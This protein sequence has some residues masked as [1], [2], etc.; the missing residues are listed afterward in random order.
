MKK[1]FTFIVLSLLSLAVV[2]Q[3][4]ASVTKPTSAKDRLAAKKTQIA[5]KMATLSEIPAVYQQMN[6][7]PVA[8]LAS[9]APKDVVTLNFTS[10]D[11]FKYQPATGDWFLSMSCMD[12]DK[13]EFGY[14]VKLD[15][16]APADNCCG[17]FTYDD[18]DLEYS[19]MF[20]PTGTTTY[21]DVELEVSMQPISTN[22][23]RLM[24]EANITG[25]DGITYKVNCVHEL[26]APADTVNTIINNV[27]LI[28]NDYDFT[29]AG[30]NAVMDAKLLVRSN[31]V[32]GEHIADVDIYNSYFVYSGDTLRPMTISANI[33]P[34]QKD[35]VASYVA[36]VKLV[37]TDTVQYVIT[38]N[39]PLPAPTQ[40]VDVVC[41]NLTIDET[42]APTYG[43]VYAEAKNEDWEVLAMFPGRVLLPGQ[44][45]SGVQFYITNNHTWDQVEALFVDINVAMD[46]TEHWTLTGTVRCSDNVVYQ[47]N[48]I[49]E[50]P[51]ADK[52]V[53]ITYDTPATVWFTPEENYKLEFMN[54]AGTYFCFIEVAGVVPGIPFGVDKVNLNNSFLMNN[55]TWDMPQISD[56]KGVIEQTGDTTKII[57]SLICFDG[58]QYDVEMY[59]AIPTP[60]KTIEYTL[61]AEFMDAIESIGA[62]QLM[63]YT[64]DSL[65]AITLAPQATQ[66]EGTYINDGLFGRLGQEGGHFD[67]IDN[68][69]YVAA[70]DPAYNGLIMHK[71]LKAQMIVTVDGQGKLTA[72]VD[73]ICD[74]AVRY[75]LT[76]TSSIKKSGLDYDAE[77][78]D[79]ERTYTSSDVVSIDHSTDDYGMMIL[80]TVVADDGSDMMSMLFF[81]DELDNSIVIPEG[82]YSINYSELSGTI[83]AN[84][85]V[86]DG[87]VYPSFYAKC[88]ANGTLMVPM[89]MFVSGT[90]DV[91]KKN[92]KLYMEIDAL[93]SNK[94]PVHIIYDASMTS[95]VESIIIDNNE[96]VKIIKN[97]QLIIKKNGVQ[98]NA[99]GT[100]VK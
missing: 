95:G 13:P 81:V 38:M 42:L 60:I 43:Y 18:F 45:T 55:D 39:S 29:F 94:V 8:R 41:T 87:V 58:V 5:E 57:A 47:L 71:I 78:G 26:V 68:Y 14:M 17:I 15:Y 36:N 33:V 21:S 75:V 99:N 34:E 9:D 98:Y 2:A 85:G 79:V 37:T 61:E 65:F 91:M 54:E 6:I 72:L 64:P 44:Y 56:V 84:P 40:Y 73:V 92:G 86:I 22:K 82:Q 88:N 48:L 30:K 67:F 27:N 66:I 52:V 53:N 70:Y 90:V 10:L 49:W 24:V 77:E 83:M 76:L 1:I 69:T 100:V 46:E 20:T 25:N 51:V 50:T 89:Y 16:F 31:R 96:P 3:T 28:Q 97:N 4:A 19:Y 32:Q 35:G 12:M 93:N 7:A 74:N 23:A 80:F 62:F 63:A 59:Y 11:D